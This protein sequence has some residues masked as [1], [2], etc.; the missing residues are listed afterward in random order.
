VTFTFPLAFALAG[1]VGGC[2]GGT[3]RLF[4]HRRQSRNSPLRFVWEGGA[5]GVLAVGAVTAGMLASGLPASV[6][7]TELGAFMIAAVGG[8][9]GAPWVDRLT[10]LTTKLQ[11]V[12]GR[13]LSP[14]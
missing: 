1:I 11:T 9:A 8:Y 4:R 3:T 2:L 14:V 13:P 12:V 5:A 10:R 6:V 7:G